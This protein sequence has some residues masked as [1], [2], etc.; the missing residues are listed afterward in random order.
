M[1]QI[2]RENCWTGGRNSI[3]K[4]FGLKSTHMIWKTVDWWAQ[5]NFENPRTGRS[6]S[7]VIYVLENPILLSKSMD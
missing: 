1:T 3:L 5:L 6:S 4:I 2:Y 7:L